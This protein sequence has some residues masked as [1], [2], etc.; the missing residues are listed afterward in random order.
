MRFSFVI[1]AIGVLL[2]TVNALTI[3]SPASGDSL[4]PTQPITIRWTSNSSDPSS[5][6][7]ILDNSNQN[8]LVKNKKI[9]T[10]IS[11]SSGS[12]ILSTATITTYGSG[13]MFKAQTTS[14]NTLST[15]GSFTLAVDTS[16]VVTSN[17]AVSFQ[18]TYTATVLASSSFS[19]ALAA[20]T[21]TQTTSNSATKAESLVAQ[22]TGTERTNSAS[23]TSNTT[24]S[25]GSLNTGFM[26]STVSRSSSGSTRS[27]SSSA[28]S[29]T[30]SANAQ[31]RVGSGGQI[32]F[33]AAGLIAGL[34]ALLA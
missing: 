3:T 28:A 12:Y 22:T 5:F 26:T 29:A 1:V 24:P 20:E 18:S 9:A 23:F 4:D 21:S 14:G 13:F 30:T 7:L 11:T 10:S 15:S 34:V 31:P 6:D 16:A 2:A 27:V 19:S 17:G 32:A 25:S 8:S 33:T